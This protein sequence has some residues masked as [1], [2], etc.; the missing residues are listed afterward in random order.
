MFVGGW[1]PAGRAFPFEK[2]PADVEQLGDAAQ[3]VG[4]LFDDRSGLG[5]GGRRLPRLG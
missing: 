2:A 3:A 1:K 5:S 4:E